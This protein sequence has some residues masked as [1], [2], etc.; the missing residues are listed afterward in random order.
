MFDQE[1]HANVNMTEPV[2]RSYL[3]HLM[4]SIIYIFFYV[5]SYYLVVAKMSSVKADLAIYYLVLG[6]S[7]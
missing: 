5:Y 7:G 6:V 1:V 3:I 2:C 4:Y